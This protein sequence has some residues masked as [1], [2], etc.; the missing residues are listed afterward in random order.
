MWSMVRTKGDLEWRQ[1]HPLPWL[2]KQW[3]L[4]ASFALC[5]FSQIRNRCSWEAHQAQQSYELERD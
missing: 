5:A 4:L 2:G 3:R 1:L